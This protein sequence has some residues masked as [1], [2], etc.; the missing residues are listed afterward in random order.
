MREMQAVEPLIQL[1]AQDKSWTVRCR[2]AVALGR[3][4]MSAPSSRLLQRS[5]Q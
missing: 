5:S 2:A 1:L 4:K 3:L